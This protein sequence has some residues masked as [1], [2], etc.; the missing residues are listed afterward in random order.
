MTASRGRP[1]SATAFIDLERPAMP[2]LS[3]ASRWR[4][5]VL[6][7]DIPLDGFWLPSPGALADP[8]AF[9][10]PYLAGARLAGAARGGP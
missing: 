2:D 5:V 3:A 9:L 7:R 1:L 4:I 10:E 8:E 6:H